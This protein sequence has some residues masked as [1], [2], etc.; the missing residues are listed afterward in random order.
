[1]I[2]HHRFPVQTSLTPGAQVS[3][4]AGGDPSQLRARLR[5][6][7]PAGRGARRL[8]CWE[9]AVTV[10]NVLLCVIRL[11]NEGDRDPFSEGDPTA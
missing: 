1:M 4:I 11:P 8:P 2:A 6:L 9:G 10:P 3:V 5:M 7:T